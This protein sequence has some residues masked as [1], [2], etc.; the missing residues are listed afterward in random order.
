MIPWFEVPVIRVGGLVTD[1]P[2]CLAVAG[3]IAAM[4]FV[5]HRA[6][7]AGLSVRR[8]VDGL[9]WIIVSA[10]FFGHTLD[11]LLYRLGDWARDWQ[12]ILPWQGGY[13][14]L[15]AC[16][17][18]VIAV[19]LRYRAPGGGLAWNDIDQ[20]VPALLLG[21]GVVRV[22][23]F[24]GH[25][26]AGRLSSF[27]LA[28]DYPGGARHDLGLY[29]ALWVFAL[30]LGLLLVE[31]HHRDRAAGVLSANA[32]FCYSLGRFALEWL[33]GSDLERIGRH[34]DPRT[35][36]LTLMQYGALAA[37]GAAVALWWRLS[38]EARAS[39]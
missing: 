32:V 28:V 24:L 33:R 21:L 2:T 5:R 4:A 6:R 9:V 37:A 25:H 36:G 39:C 19:I 22:G 34:S 38:R 23:C 20:A 30:L 13:C 11:V 15:G 3:A 26:H 8:S 27:A 29:E 35:L 1:I 14:S 16:L 18:V 17:G 12:L 7:R 31:R 10:L